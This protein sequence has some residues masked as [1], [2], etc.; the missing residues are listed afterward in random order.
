MVIDGLYCRKGEE[1]HALTIGHAGY[2]E[3]NTCTRSI[4]EESL[5]GMIIE[6]T[7]SVRYVEAVVA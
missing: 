4:Q 6:S 2:Q 5:N 1:Q 3:S 7:K